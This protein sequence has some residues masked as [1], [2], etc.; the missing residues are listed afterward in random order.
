MK[1]VNLNKNQEQ[2]ITLITPIIYSFFAI[3]I[4]LMVILGNINKAS[5][6]QYLD[7]KTKEVTCKI[8]NKYYY[9]NSYVSGRATPYITISFSFKDN[10][11][12]IENTSVESIRVNQSDFDNVKIEDEISCFITYVPVLHSD[13]NSK[14]VLEIKN[15]ELFYE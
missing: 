2:S 4:L 14:N 13:V 7:E 9:T 11:T 1:E 6:I 12:E 3:I 8:V 5:H 15:I 10:E